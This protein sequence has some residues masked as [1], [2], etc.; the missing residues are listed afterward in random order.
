MRAYNSAN[1]VQTLHPRVICT[2]DITITHR[3]GPDVALQP[4]E[5]AEYSTAGC[6]SQFTVG[7][8]GQ[9]GTMAFLSMLDVPAW[10]MVR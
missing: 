10:P 5:S 7:G 6:G 9:A 2:T 4:G 8:G 1:K 3:A